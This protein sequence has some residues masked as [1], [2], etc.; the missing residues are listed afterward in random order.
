M[1]NLPSYSSSNKMLGALP[2]P[3]RDLAELAKE[4]KGFTFNHFTCEH[5]WVI[6]N[7]L[8]NALRT[9]ECPALI[10][11]ALPTQIL[12]HSPSLPGIMPDHE[13]WVE[14]KRNTVLRWGHSTWFM[15]CQFD[16]DYKTFAEHHAMSGEEWTKYTIE[17]G[18]YPV[19]VKGVEG[20]VGAIA[21][22]GPDIAGVN[23]HSLV[24]KA[25][26]EYKELREGFR[27]PMRSMTVK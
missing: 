26:E 16:G 17:G 5:A 10:H 6:G 21:I 24:V 22:A 15:S 1:S 12:F 19:F 8:R 18:G 14:R 2:S 9:A 27:S 3:S 7:I 4:E 11:I 25:V 20:V 23:A 13:K